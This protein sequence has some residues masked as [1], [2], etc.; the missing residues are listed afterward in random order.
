[1][2]IYVVCVRVLVVF[3]DKSLPQHIYTE[4]GS[5]PYTECDFTWNLYILG[6]H[7]AKPQKNYFLMAVPLR[8]GGRDKKPAIQGKKK[9]YISDGY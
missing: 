4:I 2:A 6:K 9:K 5:I 7:W 8:R 3:Y 1:M